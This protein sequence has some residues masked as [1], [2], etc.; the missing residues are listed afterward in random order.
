MGQTALGSD[1]TNLDAALGPGAVLPAVARANW[2]RLPL[3]H[4]KGAGPAIALGGLDNRPLA[5]H[6]SWREE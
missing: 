4:L 6:L 3:L 1:L 2:A 5:P